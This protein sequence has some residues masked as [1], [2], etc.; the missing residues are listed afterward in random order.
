M[1]K[2]LKKIIKVRKTIFQRIKKP[3]GW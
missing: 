1:R 3:N 2:N